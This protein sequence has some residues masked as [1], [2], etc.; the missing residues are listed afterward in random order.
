MCPQRWTRPIARPRGWA[1][2]RG[3]ALADGARP[4]GV[5]QMSQLAAVGLIAFVWSQ[6]DGIVAG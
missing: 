5:G 3:L 4:P 2:H 1:T 6:A